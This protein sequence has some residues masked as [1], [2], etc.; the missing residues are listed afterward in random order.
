V[1]PV[2]LV[3]VL[4]VLPV[5]PVLLVPVLLVLPVLP[6]LLVPVLLVLPVLPV[7]LVPALPVSPIGC[8]LIDRSVGGEYVPL[9][10]A[11]KPTVTDWPGAMVLS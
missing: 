3:P 2:L 11:W 4:L 6:V 7:L 8:P 10:A 5:L 1:L 9:S